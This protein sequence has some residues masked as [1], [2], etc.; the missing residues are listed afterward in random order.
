MTRSECAPWIRLTQQHPARPVEGGLLVVHR[1]QQVLVAVD[2]AGVDAL[3]VDQHLRQSGHHGAEVGQG[4]T[5][6]PTWLRASA[7]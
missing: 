2:P 7:R 3:D 4:A 1:R 6:L 5:G